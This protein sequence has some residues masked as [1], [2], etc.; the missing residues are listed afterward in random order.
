MSKKK[1]KDVNL[2]APRNVGEFK[3]GAYKGLDIN[4]IATRPGSMDI[5]SSPSRIS[6]TLFHIDGTTTK[7]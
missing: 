6:G 4:K 7:G 2:V 1:A 5:L 3:R